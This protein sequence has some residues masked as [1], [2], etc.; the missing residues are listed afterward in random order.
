MKPEGVEAISMA[1]CFA[2]GQILI[3]LPVIVNWSRAANG[4]LKRNP[5][6]GVR[7]PS[8]MRSEQAWVAGNRA[9][10]RLTPVCLLTIAATSV[11]LFAVALHGWRTIVVVV[12]IGGLVAILALFIYAAVIASKAARSAAGPLH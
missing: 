10:L 1:G 6:I 5:Y 4:R 8:T 7:T 11:A 2:F 3:S 9:A 12:G